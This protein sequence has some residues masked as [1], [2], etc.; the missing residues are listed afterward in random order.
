M[1]PRMPEGGLEGGISS[2]HAAAP[3]QYMYTKVTALE[4]NQTSKPEPRFLEFNVD[5]VRYQNFEYGHIKLEN[6]AVEF[7]RPRC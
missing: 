2:Q 3:I 7:I 4:G 5:R 1:Q 6:N